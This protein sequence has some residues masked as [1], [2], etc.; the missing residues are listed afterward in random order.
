MN[1]SSTMIENVYY[2]ESCTLFLLRDYDVIP[3]NSLANPEISMYIFLSEN[4]GRIN[5]R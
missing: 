4:I 3:L 2:G 5:R 1:F